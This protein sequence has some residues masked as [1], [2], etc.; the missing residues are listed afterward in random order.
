[1]ISTHKNRLPSHVTIYAQHATSHIVM[2]S[3]W[4]LPSAPRFANPQTS[5]NCLAS[6]RLR[7]GVSNKCPLA[8]GSH[9]IDG[10]KS[11]VLNPG[12][13]ITPPRF[14]LRSST[15]WPQYP[16]VTPTSTPGLYDSRSPTTRVRLAPL[17]NADIVCPSHG[18]PLYGRSIH[19]PKGDIRRPNTK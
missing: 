3:L 13:C 8:T 6:C 4:V 2:T 7:H 5:E 1:M 18:L 10:Q 9:M 16:T 17:C 19:G 11:P 12:L 14:V 15:S